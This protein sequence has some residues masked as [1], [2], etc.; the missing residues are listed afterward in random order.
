MKF[1]HICTVKGEMDEME[2]NVHSNASGHTFIEQSVW[3]FQIYT[4]DSSW[5][6]VFVAFWVL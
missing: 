2:E 3:F 1:V 6:S 4:S 5:D